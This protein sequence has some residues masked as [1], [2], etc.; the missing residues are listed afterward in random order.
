MGC[1][2]QPQGEGRKLRDE[3]DRRLL[4]RL[5][6]AR[7]VQHPSV[8]QIG[9]N[10][11]A[12]SPPK[13]GSC[14]DFPAS[15]FP[16]S[17]FQPFFPAIFSQPI[18]LTAY[19]CLLAF[20]CLR[21]S[22]LLAAVAGEFLG[23]TKSLKQQSLQGG[24]NMNHFAD[25]SRDPGECRLQSI[26]VRRNCRNHWGRWSRGRRTQA[27]PPATDGCLSRS[28]LR[29][30]SGQDCPPTPTP[31]RQ[32]CSGRGIRATAPCRLTV[33]G[34]NRPTDRPKSRRRSAFLETID[35]DSRLHSDAKN[36]GRIRV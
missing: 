29:A 4:Q 25:P 17:F 26:D 1:G 20:S 15:F 5:P 14:K 32:P 23:A 7:P 36:N 27:P 35:S 12:A 30:G 13:T 9:W 31:A 34:G 2:R 28:T 16:A 8:H 18:F 11:G 6:G 3:D 19:A 33:S 10:P 24:G 22:V 21:S